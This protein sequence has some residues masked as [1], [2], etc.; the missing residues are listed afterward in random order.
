MRIILPGGGVKGAFQ[1]GFVDA[2]QRSG[3]YDIDHV[4]GTSVGALIAPFV[5]SGRIHKVAEQFRSLRSIDD[6]VEKWPW[7]VNMLPTSVRVMFKLGAFK[8]LKLADRLIAMLR[9][10]NIPAREYANCSVVAWDVLNKKEKWWSGESDDLGIGMKA[11]SNLWLLVPPLKTDNTYYIDGGATELVP[12]SARHTG[13]PCN[14][15]I[16]VVLRCERRRTPPRPAKDIPGNA[17]ELMRMLHQ[18][19]YMQLSDR[20]VDA[21]SRD[22]AGGRRV[23]ELFPPEDI[24]DHAMEIDPAKMDTF[25]R[26]GKEAFDRFDTSTQLQNIDGD[27]EFTCT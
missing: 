6:L 16:Y 8:S 21:F 10:D 9:E 1:V 2:M 24:F 18:D 14:P 5:A 23:V 4:Y 13:L 20:E 22:R 25:F 3:K 27:F 12:I 11:S 26:F 19:A 7:Y 17:L 15:C